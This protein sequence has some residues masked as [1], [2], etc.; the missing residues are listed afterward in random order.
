MFTFSFLQWI[1]T[2]ILILDESEK[3]HSQF[4]LKKKIELLA[5]IG[6]LTTPGM[7]LNGIQASS[8]SCIDGINSAT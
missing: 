5:I 2:M 7:F 6:F 1:K 8:S 4:F 3:I